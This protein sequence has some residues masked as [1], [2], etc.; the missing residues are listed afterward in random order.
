MSIIFKKKG[1]PTKVA[2]QVLSKINSHISELNEEEISKY[3]FHNET[4]TNESRLDE[5]WNEIQGVPIQKEETNT[6]DVEVKTK[7]EKIDELKTDS[8]E[9]NEPEEEKVKNTE[10]EE[11]IPELI[12]NEAKEQQMGEEVKQPG[13]GIP[14]S[15]NPLSKPIKTRSYNKTEN[16][17]VGDIPEPDFSINTDSSKRL[18][19]INRE[20]LEFQEGLDSQSLEEEETK[21]KDW[22]NVTNESMNNLSEGERQFA[23]KQLVKT[24]LDGY[25]TLHELGK[26]Y[27]KYPEHKIQDKI[28][29][30]EID[31]TM[32]IPIDEHGTTTNIVEF[33]Q[34]FNEQ[35][36][37]ALTYDPAFGEKVTPPMERI[38]AKKGWGMTDEQFV[39]V[40]FSKDIAWKGAQIF[41]LK[42]TANGI[43]ETFVKLQTDKNDAIRQRAKA[44]RESR[45]I[46]PDSIRT[47]PP[48]REEYKPTPED[49]DQENDYEDLGE[50]EIHIQE[51]EIN[52]EEEIT[53][54][55]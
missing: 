29:N 10:I 16:I 26:G 9:K 14:K 31:P 48:K 41:S 42:K 8:S 33:F 28:I 52:N 17:D 53:S 35:A 2:K 37:E 25:E 11:A 13:G 38:F 36:D 39:L 50:E 12:N 32:V 30:K 21:P 1:R 7:S 5:I 4:V 43:M 27:A 54:I 34:N 45:A 15:F 3:S 44:E 46:K 18:E 6:V 23:A 22:D 51:E 19:E 24:V 40:A 55:H 49:L 20:S 47:P